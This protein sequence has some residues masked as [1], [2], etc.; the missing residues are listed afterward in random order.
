MSFWD[1]T[2]WIENGP[3]R[4]PEPRRTTRA[5]DW[6]ATAL[7]LLLMPALLVM[8]AGA[9]L[10]AK[11]TSAVWISDGSTARTQPALQFGSPFMVGYSTREREPWALAEC[12]PNGTTTFSNTYADGTIWS[13]VFSVYTGG[14]S[15]QSFVLGASI[16]PLWTGGG[17]DCVVSLVTYSRDLSRQTVLATASFT[18][19]P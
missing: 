4:H 16:Y 10:A 9:A 19:E 3:R 6:V 7:M 15:P 18:V 1:G 17:A 5:A 12:Y 11:P 14:P 13:E 2:R 8:M